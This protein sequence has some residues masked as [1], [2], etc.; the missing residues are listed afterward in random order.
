MI[1]WKRQTKR[2][3]SN[4]GS[5][6]AQDKMERVAKQKER[7]S[8]KEGEGLD[9]GILQVSYPEGMVGAQLEAGSKVSMCRTKEVTR[10]LRAALGMHEWE[11]RKKNLQTSQEERIVW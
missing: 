4:C 6:R 1:H 10:K 3:I 9:L 5:C 2:K 7:F 8:T 11:L